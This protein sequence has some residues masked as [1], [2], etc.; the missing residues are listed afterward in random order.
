MQEP[1]ITYRHME[2]S[3]ALDQRIVEQAGKLNAINPKIT[4]CHVVVDEV[5]RHKSKGNLFE[6]HVVLHVP[7][8]GEV[9]S[10]RR[11]HEDP[12]QAVGEAFDA[13]RREL[14]DELDLLRRDVKR[15]DEERGDE[16]QP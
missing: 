10:T 11:A 3:A 13:V 1:Q 14:Q 6:V 4:S 9:V 7:G 15:H 16:A 2:H 12:Y 8:R 5:D